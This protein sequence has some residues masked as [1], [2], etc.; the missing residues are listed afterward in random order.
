ML[1]GIDDLMLSVTPK[2]LAL[3]ETTG[4]IYVIGPALSSHVGIITPHRTYIELD[5]E[6][7]PPFAETY[8]IALHPGKG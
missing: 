4:N 6:T 8:A 7:I 2:R 3:D 5:V 1:L